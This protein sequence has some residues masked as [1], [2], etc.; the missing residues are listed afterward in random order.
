[1]LKV[2]FGLQL[3]I[4]DSHCYEKT[5]ISSYKC[6]IFKTKQIF[7]LGEP[8]GIEKPPKSSFTAQITA[9][10]PFFLKRQ[11]SLLTQFTGSPSS[12]SI[13][14]RRYNQ[15][16]HFSNAEEETVQQQPKP[17]LT[18]R[19]TDSNLH[20]FIRQKVSEELAVGQKQKLHKQRRSLESFD[21]NF[22]NNIDSKRVSSLL[23]NKF[24]SA[25]GTVAEK[26]K[27][28]KK[29]LPKSSSSIAF[30]FAPSSKLFDFSRVSALNF[31]GDQHFDVKETTTTSAKPCPKRWNSCPFPKHLVVN[32]RQ[33]EPVEKNS[34]TGTGKKTQT[35]TVFV[36]HCTEDAAISTKLH[37]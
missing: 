24:E 32:N 1:L 22:N 36:F 27:K 31:S 26:S 7:H 28:K 5:I 18:K 10:V 15:E 3:Q 9:E 2:S 23:N 13:F 12:S 19:F 25:L 21:E 17:R 20:H 8:S 11:G 16:D 14:R 30:T 6:Q 33:T 29:P 35:P 34:V 4:R 37:F